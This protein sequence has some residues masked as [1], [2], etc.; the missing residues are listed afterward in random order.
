MVFEKSSKKPIWNKNVQVVTFFKLESPWLVTE[1]YRVSFQWNG[2]GYWVLLG[3]AKTTPGFDEISV[4]EK[5][6]KNEEI[7]KKNKQTKQRLTGRGRRRCPA[8]CC[9]TGPAGPGTRCPSW[10]PCWTFS[11]PATAAWPAPRFCCPTP[12]KKTQRP[13]FTLAFLPGFTGFS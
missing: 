5:R 8:A 1:L 3:F 13:R 12:T 9:A 11:G 6:V 4:C 2:D 7:W 10:G